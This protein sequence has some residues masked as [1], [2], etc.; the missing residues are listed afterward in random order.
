MPA[1]CAPHS[2]HKETIH[3]TPSPGPRWKLVPMEELVAMC[4]LGRSSA[5]DEFTGRIRHT[6][7]RRAL[8]LTKNA[9]EAED[10]AAE[11]MLRILRRVDTIK[12]AS[13]LNAW[14]DRIVRNVWIDTWRSELP[15]RLISLDSL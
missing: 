5:V 11:S 8:F 9:S 6:V 13:S 7:Y 3:A 15:H 2:I 10:L 12:D 14:I 1:A 4:R